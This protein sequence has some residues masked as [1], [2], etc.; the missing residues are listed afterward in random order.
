[1]TIRDVAARAGVSHQTVSR[2]I[3]KSERVTPETLARVEAAIAELGYQP[4][5]IA[6]SMAKGRSR[7]LACISPNLTDFTYASIIEG[8]EMEARSHG[9]FLISA[10]APD[11]AAFSLLVKQLIGSQRTE[12]LLA[13]NPYIDARYQSMPQSVPC[14]VVGANAR[15]DTS[16][17]VAL[18]EVAASRVATQHLLN[19]GHR[20]IVHITGPLE[21][22]C[23]QDRQR[24]Y[25]QAI[26]NAGLEFDPALVIEGDWSATS[27]YQTTLRLLDDE[28]DF[29]AI[30]AQNDRIAVGAIRALREA[31]R[32]V[33]EGVSVVGFDDMPLAS[34]F[35]PPLTT[36]RQDIF[37]IGC[38]AARL[39]IQSIE[40]PGRKP[41]HVRLPA[42]L[43]VRRSTA[44]YSHIQ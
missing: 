2:V 20:R 1:M 31:G 25:Q 42:E 17:S 27:G 13:L 34:Y 10:S 14:V 44:A 26:Q 43:V 15:D 19:L 18:D 5:A 32:A 9:Y 35:D 7:T 22:D 28:V 39:L 40:Q 8:A 6:R 36:M 23:S 30:F 16:H 33:P 4:N 3:N 38:E 24:G 12:G 41:Q 29:T 37:C 11:E 21:E